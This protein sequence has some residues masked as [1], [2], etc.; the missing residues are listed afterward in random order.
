MRNA[1]VVVGTTEMCGR[2][3]KEMTTHIQH[4]VAFAMCVHIRNIIFAFNFQHEHEIHSSCIHAA[5]H[6]CVCVCSSYKI[7]RCIIFSSLILLCSTLR[8]FF[9]QIRSNVRLSGHGQHFDLFARSQ[10]CSTKLENKVIFFSIFP[11]ELISHISH[12]T[13][14]L[15]L[16]CI[17]ASNKP[18]LN[19]FRSLNVKMIIMRRFP[20]AR[21]L[22]RH[23]IFD[24]ALDFSYNAGRKCVC[25]NEKWN[26]AL[27]GDIRQYSYQTMDD[28]VVFFS[29][30][31]TI[32]E[33]HCRIQCVF[34]QLWWTVCSTKC[35]P[36]K[37]YFHF[38]II[39][40]SFVSSNASWSSSSPL[41]CEKPNKIISRHR[42]DAVFIVRSPIVRFERQAILVYL[43]AD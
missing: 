39:C 15:H 29:F 5:H 19:S 22:T 8:S 2:R 11:A 27:N 38:W 33:H 28:S 40:A 10:F 14:T 41:K 36:Q 32:T 6:R 25:K 7:R 9:F 30:Q 16:E 42:G 1:S 17:N 23:L 35:I 18:M 43:Y 20:F 3:A 31:T 24:S 37:A 4:V 12:S 21:P 13:W 26:I 34:V